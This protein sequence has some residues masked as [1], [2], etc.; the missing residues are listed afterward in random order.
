M[1]MI[2]FDSDQAQ[3]MGILLQK[4]LKFPI[5]AEE[6]DSIYHNLTKERPMDFEMFEMIVNSLGMTNKSFDNKELF[7]S[8]DASSDG[9]LTA[10]DFSFLIS[11]LSFYNLIEQEHFSCGDLFGLFDFLNT[12]TITKVEF[13]RFFSVDK[14]SKLSK[15]T[16][17]SL[18]SQ[19]D[20]AN[21]GVLS[22]EEF[23]IGMIKHRLYKLLNF[24][25]DQIHL[26]RSEFQILYGRS[27]ADMYEANMKFFEID[28]KQNGFIDLEEMEKY[29]EALEAKADWREFACTGDMILI[30]LIFIFVF[31]LG[32][33]LIMEPNIVDLMEVLIGIMEIYFFGSISTGEY[34]EYRK[35]I[36]TLR[37]ITKALQDNEKITVSAQN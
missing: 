34:W 35:D 24:N 27:G 29:I 1:S 28:L 19:I 17:D 3:V 12:G 36:R 22:F 5:N 7:A 20:T 26:T 4:Q 31:A 10:K 6:R 11:V 23:V 21:S 15:E 2:E 8:A 18:F 9:T 30:T 14:S 16:L 33:E 32:Y 13:D 25:G 37:F